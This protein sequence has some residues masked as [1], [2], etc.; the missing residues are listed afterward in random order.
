MSVLRTCD[1]CVWLVSYIIA[2][3]YHF[4]R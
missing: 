4:K 1:V 2:A 3:R